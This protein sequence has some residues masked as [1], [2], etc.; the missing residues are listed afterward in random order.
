MHACVCVCARA[1]PFHVDARPSRR[2]FAKRHRYDP[3]GGR[4]RGFRSSGIFGDRC[5]QL[6][7]ERARACEPISTMFHC[8]CVCAC[9]YVSMFVLHAPHFLPRHPKARPD[10]SVSCTPTERLCTG[11][12]AHVC[13]STRIMCVLNV[14]YKDAPP[15]SPSPLPSTLSACFEHIRMCASERASEANLQN[16]A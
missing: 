13:K 6:K 15:E 12:C 11:P 4:P 7:S 3:N 2:Q 10:M 5:Q 1:R 14:G 9:A 16:F 8:A